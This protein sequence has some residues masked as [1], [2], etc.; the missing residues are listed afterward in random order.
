MSSDE[1]DMVQ[2]E[3]GMTVDGNFWG[4]LNIVHNGDTYTMDFSRT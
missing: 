1:L 2:M 3:D 4:K